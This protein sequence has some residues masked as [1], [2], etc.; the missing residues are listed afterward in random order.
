MTSRISQTLHQRSH[1]LKFPDVPELPTSNEAALELEKDLLTQSKPDVCFDNF[2]KDLVSKY[3]Y[4]LRKYILTNDDYDHMLQDTISNKTLIQFGPFYLFRL[5]HETAVQMV[6]NDCLILPFVKQFCKFPS[7]NFSGLK[8]EE[9]TCSIREAGSATAGSRKHKYAKPAEIF[10]MGMSRLDFCRILGIAVVSYPINPLTGEIIPKLEY[11]CSIKANQESVEQEIQRIEKYEKIY[12]EQIMKQHARNL[13]IDAQLFDETT[14]ENF[15]LSVK[16]EAIKQVK[17]HM[18]QFL[19]LFVLKSI[20]KNAL[21]L[22]LNCSKDLIPYYASIGFKM[23]PTPSFEYK[24]PFCGHRW[25]IYHNI[26]A[27]SDQ[28]IRDYYNNS[29][30]YHDDIYVL[31][32]CL[33][34]KIKHHPRQQFIR[35]LPYTLTKAWID[36]E[37]EEGLYN[38]HLD[39]DM[40][41]KKTPVS[42]Q[43]IN[44]LKKQK[45]AV[46]YLL[47]IPNVLS[48]IDH[49][50]EFE[51]KYDE[52]LDLNF[53]LFSDNE[54][55]DKQSFKCFELLFDNPKEL[56]KKIQ[57]YHNTKVSR[58]SKS[59]IVG[60]N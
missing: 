31:D 18:G 4:H 57:L 2:M 9:M 39:L 46:L 21:Y 1:L 29:S 15:K 26:K 55:P 20:K 7:M 60:K 44:Q 17:I 33:E 50:E 40:E 59:F 16:L 58:F 32:S 37:Q 48:F 5:A 34:Y 42:S 19:L 53:Q 8:E 3:G 22:K 30:E 12:G 56:A 54:S 28:Q 35:K 23:G 41:D 27:A 14:E 11:F 45:A 52:D 38:M 51:E 10:F 13:K 43:L 36:V 24:L 47:S 49:P 6:N 25:L